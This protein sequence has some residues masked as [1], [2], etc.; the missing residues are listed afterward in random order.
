MLTIYLYDDNK[1]YFCE[2]V[3]MLDPEETKKQGREVWLMP[4]NATTVKP[5]KKD[6]YAPVWNGK[7]WKQV[8]DHR[9][10]KGWVNREPVEIKDLGP[11][12]DG[13]RVEKPEPTKEELAEQQRLEILSELDRIDRASSRSLRA[14]LIAQAAGV[15]PDSMDMEMLSEY[16]ASAKALR[17]ALRNIEG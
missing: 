12:P 11:L 16:E 2:T 10:K 5:T 4:P 9:G 14:I 13:F 3:T 15:A 1:E 7:A 8:E 6:G 17:V